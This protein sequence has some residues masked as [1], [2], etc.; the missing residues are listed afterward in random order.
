MEDL[1]KGNPRR[2][3]LISPPPVSPPLVCPSRGGEQCI[4]WGGAMYKIEG[5]RG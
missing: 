4:K 1:G 5:D 2:N 3:S